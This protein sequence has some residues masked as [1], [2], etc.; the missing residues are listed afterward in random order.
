M[1][2]NDPIRTTT[3]PLSDALVAA[4]TGAIGLTLADRSAGGILADPVLASQFIGKAAFEKALAAKIV[5]IAWGA[6]QYAT[7][8]EGTDL[9]VLDL[10][11]DAATVTPARKGFARQMSDMGRSLET[12]GITDYANF[13]MDG[14]IG[15]QQTVVNVL[16]ALFTS[17]SATGGNSGGAATWGTILAD[18]VTLGQ[19][20]VAG[21]YVLI[22]RPKDWGN[23]AQDAYA[24]GGF[25]ANDPDVAGMRRAVNPGFMGSFMNGNLRVYTS[26]ELPTS[27]GDTVSGLFGASALAWNAH[28]PAPS[29]DT[30]PILWTPLFGVET[31]RIVLKNEDYISYS[32]HLGASVDQNAAG[33]QLPFLT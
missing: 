18:M 30:K 32:T 10:A 28:M 19:A 26:Q 8:A 29:A 31:Q 11:S 9:T 2:A 13:A 16:A 17:F 21:P 22:T 23:V 33:I 7:T 12:W 5:S 1:G 4:V 6:D 3:E 14:T 20:N 25:A 24:L 27:G 15:W